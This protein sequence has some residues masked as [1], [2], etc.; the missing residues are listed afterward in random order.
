MP[1]VPIAAVLG[2]AGFLAYVAGVVVLADRVF[3][4]H[5]TLQ[6]LFFLTAGVLW[7]LPAHFLILWAARKCGSRPS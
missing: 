2:V 3:A 7:V 4:L 1:R 5:W 6:A